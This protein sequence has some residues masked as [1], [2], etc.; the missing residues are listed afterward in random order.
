MALTIA[1]VA[2]RTVDTVRDVARELPEARDGRAALEVLTGGERQIY[3]GV[4]LAA[5][6][7]LLL[8]FLS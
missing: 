5:A 6:A 4:A 8:L 3:V 7:L 2:K 1:E